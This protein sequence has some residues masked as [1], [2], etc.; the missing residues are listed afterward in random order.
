VQTRY[1]VL[2]CLVVIGL[3]GGFAGLGQEAAA[4]S[5]ARDETQQFTNSAPCSSAAQITRHFGYT[6]PLPEYDFASERFR[7]I[8]PKHEDTHEAWG[9]RRTKAAVNFH[10]EFGAELISP[11]LVP[12]AG[13]L[14]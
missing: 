5:R 3:R 12:G 1:S 8:L 2:V 7:V 6:V 11:A 9:P 4:G 13:P 14:S 10:Q